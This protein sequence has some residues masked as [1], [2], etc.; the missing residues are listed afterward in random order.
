M[1]RQLSAQRLQKYLTH[2]RKEDAETAP[3]RI[4]AALKRRHLTTSQGAMLALTLR[5]LAHPSTTAHPPGHT[6]PAVQQILTALRR[7]ELNASQRA[8]LAQALTRLARRSRAQE[9]PALQAN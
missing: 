1:P 8:M 3:K 7:R 4:L 5:R 9:T 2:D 6:D